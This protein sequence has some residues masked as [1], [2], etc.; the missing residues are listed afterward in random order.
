MFHTYVQHIL[1]WLCIAYLECQWAS[2]ASSFWCLLFV[3]GMHVW[4]Y[5]FSVCAYVQ[6]HRCILRMS[7]GVVL[8]YSLHVC[9]CSYICTHTHVR[10]YASATS[11]PVSSCVSIYTDISYIIINACACTQ[12]NA[13]ILY[14]FGFAP[15]ITWATRNPV[16]CRKSK[17]SAMMFSTIAAWTDIHQCIHV[18]INLQPT[19][20]EVNS[21][22][23]EAMRI[24]TFTNACTPW[25]NLQ[26]ASAFV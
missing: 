14:L 12:I 5:K 10:A 3:C 22:K 1:K 20:N 23:I 24:H 15:P 6:I 4:I 26:P 11:D 18:Y 19:P 9:M 2:A 7:L 17:I 8:W 16:S 13:I 21:I 25:S